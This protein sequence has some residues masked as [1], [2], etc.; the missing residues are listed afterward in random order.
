MVKQSDYLD[1]VVQAQAGDQ[2]SMGQ[3]AVRVRHRLYPYLHQVTSDH[4]L[5]QDLLQDV[6][7]AMVR[8]VDTLEQPESFWPWIYGIA[9][10]KIQEQFRVQRRREILKSAALNDAYYSKPAAN[11]HSAFEHVVDRE[12]QKGLSAAVKMLKRKYRYVVQLRCFEE[13]SYS[14]IAS[15]MRCSPQQARV[16]FFRAK[17]CLKNS[18]ALVA[19]GAE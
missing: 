4:H 14:Q 17:K 6:L 1:L 10:R 7:L 2:D 16:R 9:R 13:M 19:L 8:S 5:S 18:P 12:R 15:V 3:L 11:D